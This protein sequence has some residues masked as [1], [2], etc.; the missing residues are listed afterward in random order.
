MQNRINVPRSTTFVR[1]SASSKS[2]KGQSGGAN[3]RNTH[4][5]QLI[6]CTSEGLSEG[7]ELGLKER[8]EEKL[9]IGSDR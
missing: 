8:V 6:T 9:A 7:W 5:L 3:R 2:Y 4:L 1:D